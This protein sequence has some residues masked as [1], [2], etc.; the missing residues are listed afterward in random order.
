MAKRTI[1]WLQLPADIRMNIRHIGGRLGHGSKRAGLSF[2]IDGMGHGKLIQSMLAVRPADAGFPTAGVEA[3]HC[4]E[5]LTVDISLAKLQL[6][7]RF[8]RGIQIAGIDGRGQAIFAVIGQC[9]G[10]VETVDRL[11]RQNRRKNR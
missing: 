6:A 3:L 7:R 1:S 10:F 4:L 5:I 9:D 2:D 8:H 11:N